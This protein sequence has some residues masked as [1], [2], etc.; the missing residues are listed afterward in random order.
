[1]KHVS[2]KIICLIFWACVIVFSGYGDEVT[3]DLRT[4]V[5][6]N[7]NGDSEY[8]WKTAANKFITTKGD[9]KYPM[10]TYVEAWPMAAFGQNRNGDA[11][12]SLGLLGK[13]DRMGYNWIDIYPVKADD[14]NEEPYEI[15]LPGRVRNFDMWVWGSNLNYYI[16]LYVRDYTG[17]V[18]VLKLGDV[19]YTGWKNLQVNVPGSIPQSKRKLPSYA[20]LSFVKFRLW[21]N[22]YEKTD[23]FYIYFKQLKVLSDMFESLFDGNDLADPELVDQL[24]NGGNK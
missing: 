3:N 2:F 13:F 17:V 20:G 1:M 6:E 19:G 21:T 12:K 15:P 24:W 8:T 11:I 22:P 16:E 18:H 10:T 4:V 9:K 14:S 5:L 23:E 7:F